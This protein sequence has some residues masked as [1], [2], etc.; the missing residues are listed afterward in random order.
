VARFETRC[1][2]LAYALGVRW[3]APAVV[4]CLFLLAACSSPAPVEPPRQVTTVQIGASPEP[5]VVVIQAAPEPPTSAGLTGQSGRP[6]ASPSPVALPLS[7]LAGRSA[8]DVRISLDLLLQEQVYLSAL[9]MDAATS[10]R[11][12]ELSGVSTTLDQNSL[13]FAE[14]LGA[15]KDQA[16]AQ[17]LLDAWRGLVNDLIAYAQGQQT[18]ATA[19]L[20]R[21]RPIIATQLALAG[22]SQAQID[23]LLRA[24]IQAMLSLA[25]AIVAHDA[26]QSTQRLGATV[27]ASDDLARVLAA[28]IAKQVPDR[29]PPPSEG[30]DIDVRVGLTRA[31]QAHAYLTGAAT[32]AAADG[33]S[34]DLEALVG[35]ANANAVALGAQLGDVYGPDL[36]SG[37]ADRLRAESASLV[38]SA[39][40]GD[41]H[42][43]MADLDRLRGELDGLLSGANTLIPPGLLKQELRAT[44]QT[45]LTATDAFAARDFATSFV[46]LRDAARQSQKAADSLAQTIVDRYPS[47]YFVMA[48]PT[49][50]R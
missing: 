3:T 17:A 20:D 11:L 35:A 45:L 15:V 5:T 1:L 33:R 7:V 21:Q 8:A 34:A 44:D 43:T 38:A 25:D 39:S 41:R 9:A 10:A 48:T 28:A 29:A 2:A 40:G 26:G 13:A 12:D 14:V 36:A 47:R 49:P 37:V 24:R 6:A 23:D 16:A 42:Q 18:T 30:R 4:A 32:D 46:R 31:F 27:M 22:G 50:Q 19:D